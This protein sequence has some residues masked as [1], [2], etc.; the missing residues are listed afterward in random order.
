MRDLKTWRIAPKELHD[1]GEEREGL[2]LFARKGR[3]SARFVVCRVPPLGEYTATG[4]PLDFATALS[5]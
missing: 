1:A 3:D 4:I 2:C 5:T